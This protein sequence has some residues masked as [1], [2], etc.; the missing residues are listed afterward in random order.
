MK[1]F[2]LFIA[3]A[4]LAAPIYAQNIATVNGQP[5]TQQAY[6]QFIK[7]LGTQGAPDTPQLREQVKEEM[8]NRLV[9]VQAAEKAGITKQPDVQT[10]L[11]LARQG[12]LVRALMA[13]YLEKNPVTEDKVKAEYE[14]LKKDQ[15]EVLE[16]NVRHILVEDEATANG[17]QKQLKDKTAKFEDLAKAQSKD[18][19]SAAQG[20]SLGW[21]SADNYVAPFAQAVKNTPKGQ[22]TDKPVQTQFG[23]HVIEVV[24]ARPIAFPPF[25]EV[26]T[27]LEEMM[28]QQ[29]L[30]QFQQKLRSEAKID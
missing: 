20:G 11:E 19:G 29:E 8:I 22:M 5:I 2:A 18:P 1:R 25:E 15:G 23:W 4:T 21:A 9:M 16:Y 13:D 14:K 7:L 10:E 27:Q 24:D 6:D 12:I 26:R 28:R 3:A 30:V 17:L